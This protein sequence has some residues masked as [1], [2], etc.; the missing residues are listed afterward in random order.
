MS[1]GKSDDTKSPTNQQPLTIAVGGGKGGVGKSMVTANLAVALAQE[2]KQV[3][4]VDTDLGAANLHIL[5]DE[6]RPKST[7]VSFLRKEV[8]EL[9]DAALPTGVEGLSLVAGAGAVPGVANINYGQKQR[10]LRH[11]RKL[12]CDVVV[13]D[14]GAGTSHNVVDFYDVADYRLVVMTPQVTSLTNAYSFIK[15]AVYRVLAKLARAEGHKKLVPDG[16]AIREID[17]VRDLLTEVNASSPELAGHF[18]AALE[19]FGCRLVVNMLRTEK[20]MKTAYAIS[21]M[22]RDFLGLD[23][24]VIGS[25]WKSNAMHQSVDRRKPFLT[26]GALDSNAL[27][28]RRM[29]AQ[30][31]AEDVTSLRAGRQW[32][33]DLVLD[34]QLTPLSEDTRVAQESKELP[35]VDDYV[36]HSKR[37][38][39][40]WS[41]TL[42][43]SGGQ[44]AVRIR[45]VSQVGA[46]VEADL[47][48]E[49]G[50][51]ASLRFDDQPGT[52]EVVVKVRNVRAE[53]RLVGLEITEGREAARDVV[54]AALSG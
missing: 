39:V 5:F 15:S 50:A 43:W 17:K 6:M 8:T 3:V 24:P 54:K 4:L 41:G 34:D 27:T 36:E 38:D 42:T 1:N 31:L 30:L 35:V 25:L 53:E 51:E 7:L 21:R 40:D 19:N 49:V 47:A 14:I 32:S 22:A 52:P 9:T 11:I 37:H 46:M 12:Q 18:G 20:E 10:L 48:V 33:P 29:A 16:Q 13:L 23:S 44:D 2:G 28:I 45:N 26:T